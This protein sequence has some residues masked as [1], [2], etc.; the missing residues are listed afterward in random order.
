[1]TSLSPNPT[2][3]KAKASP[4]NLEVPKGSVKRIMKLNQEVPNVSAVSALILTSKF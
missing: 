1:M 2:T 3:D 4:V